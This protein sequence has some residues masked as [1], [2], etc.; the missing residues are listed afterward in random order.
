MNGHTYKEPLTYALQFQFETEGMK[1][2]SLP[3]M[4]VLEH[5]YKGAYYYWI[6]KMYWDILKSI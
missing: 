5:V 4:T 6:T 2:M 3:E 1:K